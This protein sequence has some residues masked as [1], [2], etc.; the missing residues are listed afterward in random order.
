MPFFYSPPLIYIV[1]SWSDFCNIWFFFE[2]CLKFDK[3]ISYVLNCGRHVIFWV[4]FALSRNLISLLLILFLSSG[5]SSSLQSSKDSATTARKGHKEP[6][7]NTFG[8]TEL[9]KIISQKEKKYNIPT[10]YLNSIARVESEISPYAVNAG[11][12]SYKFKDKETASKFVKTKMESGTKNVS[13][14]CMQIHLC[15]LK[16]FDSIDDAIDPNNNIDY[17]AKLFKQLYDKYGNLKEA[18]QA[19]HSGKR[20]NGRSYYNKVMKFYNK[21]T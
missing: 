12:K 19:Y 15:H 1:Y 14:G 7:A 21:T 5:C 16:H 13:V 17:A 2:F 20:N 18:I 4:S 8:K 6:A 11:K 3:K 10:G 9:Q